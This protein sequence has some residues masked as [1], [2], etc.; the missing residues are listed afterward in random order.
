MTLRDELH[1]LKERSAKLAEAEYQKAYLRAACIMV[2]TE[3]T[4]SLGYKFAELDRIHRI[5][6]EALFCIEETGAPEAF[7]FA[8]ALSLELDMYGDPNYRGPE[9]KGIVNTCETLTPNK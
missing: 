1:A 4:T 3:Y 9:P 8:H 6:D 7:A 5:A 2:A